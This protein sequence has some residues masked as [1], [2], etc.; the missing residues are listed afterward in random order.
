M[1]ALAV[2]VL[3]SACAPTCE[4]TCRKLDSCAADGSTVT[5]IECESTCT[6]LLQSFAR[7]DDEIRKESFAAHRRCVVSASCDEI[8]DG[9]CYDETL[10]AF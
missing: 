4:R 10:Y 6:A 7:D 5:R 1:L 8:D 3:L 9:V 2:A